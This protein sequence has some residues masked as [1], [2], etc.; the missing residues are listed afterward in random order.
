MDNQDRPNYP[1]Q[2]PLYRPQPYISEGKLSNSKRRPPFWRRHLAVIITSISV[3]LMII[4]ALTTLML[5]MHS[6]SPTTTPASAS[7]VS[8]PGAPLVTG[9]TPTPSPATTE[10]PCK[11]N[12]STWTSNS[13][14]WVVR[15]GILYNDGRDGQS[16][17]PTI[18]AWDK[19][20]YLSG[21]GT[22]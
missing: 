8:T 15:D 6:N 18:T 4:F 7:P 11:V 10:L 20:I 9:S 5:L 12:M 3:V 19:S 21:G 2:E 1:G 14:E 22:K 13:Q 17:R 16:T